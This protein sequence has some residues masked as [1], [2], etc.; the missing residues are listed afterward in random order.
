MAETILLVIAIVIGVGNALFFR[1][2]RDA[3]ADLN[4]SEVARAR[5]R[6]ESDLWY[7][8]FVWWLGVYVN[9]DEQIRS[10]GFT[11]EIIR[12]PSGRPTVIVKKAKATPRKRK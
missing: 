2:W 12:D 11:S 8:K 9:L 4:E 7:R 6:S 1:L 5:A 10:A 3:C